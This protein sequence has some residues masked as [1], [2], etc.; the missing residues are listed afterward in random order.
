MAI[1]YGKDRHQA[2]L[3]PER[4][5]N[6]VSKDDPVRAYDVFVD[7]LDFQELGIDEEERKVGCPAY[8]PRAMLK[9]LLYGYSY[10]V[11]SS[12]K[13]E[14]AVYHNISFI[15]LMRGLRPDFKTIAE[16]RRNNKGALQ[17]ALAQCA[18]VCLKLKLVEGNVLFVDGTKIWANAGK[19]QQHDKAWYSKHLE[20]VQ[21]RIQELLDQCE[22]VDR[23]EDGGGS[24][25]EMPEELAGQEHLKE[26]IQRALAKFE[27]RGEKTKDGHAR[28]VNRVDPESAAMKSPQG[29][30]PAYSVQSVVDDAKGLIVSVDAVSDANDTGQLAEQ[31]GKA[32]ESLGRECKVAC[33]DAGYHNVEEMGKLESDQR[34]VIVPSPMQV[35]E[36]EPDAFHK[37]RFEYDEQKD[38]Y[39]CPEGRQMVFRRFQD[40]KHKKR[41]YRIKKPAWCRECRHFGECTKSKQGRTVTRHVLEDTRE[42]I[43][44]RYASAEGQEIY[45]RRKARVEHPFGYMKKALGF[46]QF[47]LRGRNGA[48]AEACLLALSFNLKRM[49]TMSGGVE[50]MMGRMAA[51]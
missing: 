44:R 11:F 20:Q 27:E 45:A 25:V 51:V 34:Q 1:R 23:E 43:A 16:F 46:R 37:S 6:Y 7:A 30:H 3:F 26:A 41:D 8:D 13:L 2:L 33:A 15:W 22:A 42:R 31:I 21:Q 39:Y 19:G 12:R 29:T 14:R 24:L 38:C 17:N 5:D 9:L 18:R 35:S 32:E 36:D 48:R 28:K 40:K 49:I 10:G 50:N 4:L 47:L